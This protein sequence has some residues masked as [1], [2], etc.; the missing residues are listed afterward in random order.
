MRV[1]LA[2]DEEHHQRGVQHGQ[3]ED[4]QDRVDQR[5]STRRAGTLRIVTSP[6]ARSVRMVA[7]KLM[8]LATEPIPKT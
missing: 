4:D 6:G 8:E 7:M 3:R 2:I 5:S 1:E